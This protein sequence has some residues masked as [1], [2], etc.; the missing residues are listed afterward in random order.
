M[1]Y[2]ISDILEGEIKVVWINDCPVY[3]LIIFWCDEPLV[4]WYET[5]TKC[6][7][8]LINAERYKACNGLLDQLGSWITSSKQQYKLFLKL[9]SFLLY[10]VLFMSE[11][12]LRSGLNYTWNYY[13]KSSPQTGIGS[14]LSQSNKTKLNTNKWWCIVHSLGSIYIQHLF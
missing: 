4:S 2:G 7:S 1:E 12:K 8:H 3:N 10:N 14:L 13:Q 6:S 5:Y 11:A 9:I